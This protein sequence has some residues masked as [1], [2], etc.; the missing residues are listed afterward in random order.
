M[1]E[2]ELTVDTGILMVAFGISEKK[3]DTCHQKL[4]EAIETKVFLA[5][6]GN[7]LNEPGPVHVE[8]QQKFRETSPVR[9]WLRFLG[10]RS[11]IRFKGK[12]RNLAK[13]LRTKL[14]KAHFDTGDHKS[15]ALAMATESK[16]IVTEDDDY[17][18]N[19]CGI[20]KREGIEVYVPQTMNEAICANLEADPLV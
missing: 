5:L 7:T 11:R 9:I 18:A 3:G 8:Y 2:I 17:T 6:D 10:S 19:V 15:V 12:P 1:A 16:C 13:N 14:A 20:L 4:K